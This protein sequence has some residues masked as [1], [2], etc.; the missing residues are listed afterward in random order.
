MRIPRNKKSTAFLVS[1]VG[2]ARKVNLQGLDSFSV[3]QD[4][5]ETMQYNSMSFI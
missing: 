5:N 4:R 2:L 1:G 3:I